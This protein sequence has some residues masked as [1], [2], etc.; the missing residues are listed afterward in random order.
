MES[1]HERGACRPQAGAAA[2]ARLTIQIPAGTAGRFAGGRWP[3]TWNMAHSKAFCFALSS[4]FFRD[5]GLP[6]LFGQ[7]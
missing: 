4:A 5:R 6:S 7:C 2:R 3:A 1:S